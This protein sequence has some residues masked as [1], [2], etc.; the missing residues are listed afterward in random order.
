MNKLINDNE[1]L[2]KEQSEVLNETRGLI[3]L[4]IEKRCLERYL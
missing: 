1:I 2:L 4:L 3:R